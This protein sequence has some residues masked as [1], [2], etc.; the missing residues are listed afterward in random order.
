MSVVLLCAA[1]P[2]P[3]LLSPPKAFIWPADR[4][5][6]STIGHARR[7]SNP[8]DAYLDDPE[9]FTQPSFGPVVVYG[10]LRRHLQCGGLF[11][12][13]LNKPVHALSW[14]IPDPASLLPLLTARLRFMIDKGWQGKGLSMPKMDLALVADVCPDVAAVS[15]MVSASP[16]VA[17]SLRHDDTYELP[18]VHGDHAAA[19]VEGCL[20]L[21]T[22]TTL[23]LR[24][25]EGNG[26]STGAAGIATE[27]NAAA[28]T[29]E[30][31]SVLIRAVAFL[32][33]SAMPRGTSGVPGPG[34]FALVRA[35]GS[36]MSSV[37]SSALNA[38]TFRRLGGLQ[39]A[40][41]LLAFSRAIEVCRAACFRACMCLPGCVLSLAGCCRK[42]IVTH[43]GCCS[44]LPR[45]TRACATWTLRSPLQ[46]TSPWATTT[47]T[48]PRLETAA[49]KPAAATTMM[50]TR[51]WI[52][53]SRTQEV[54]WLTAARTRCHAHHLPAA[55]PK[56]C[57]PVVA[58]S[59][60][61]VRIP[62]A[63]QGPRNRVALVSDTLCTVS[64]LA[65]ATGAEDSSLAP[66][67]ETPTLT[68]A[69]QLARVL[70]RDTSDTDVLPLLLSRIRAVSLHTAEPQVCLVKQVLHYCIAA[71]DD[72]GNAV[73][74][75]WARGGASVVTG[76]RGSVTGHAGA[77][78][79]AGVGGATEVRTL[80][81]AL[82]AVKTVVELVMTPSTVL[83]LLLQHGLMW[84]L[85]H[86]VL[87]D[88]PVK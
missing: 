41:A 2:L 78:V 56:S 87:S 23:F 52:R 60:L 9:V 67:T 55:C 24:S 72:E 82:Q 31:Y 69:L 26:A 15:A 71:T 43:F 81:V 21:R 18:S 14:A 5:H 65:S 8:E 44:R 20:L 51:T 11:L 75:A 73:S 77:G 45:P 32:L 35:A 39:T 3:W 59:A 68:G 63:T 86:L 1:A 22:L 33:E 16:T 74:P 62:P 88:A 37:Q 85:M 79:G 64:R 17:P 50:T 25:Q 83:P 66:S 12:K 53:P 48:T 57:V 70:G 19:I 54:R 38:A 76:I 4:P 58:C 47:T 13:V 61:A 42:V 7:L 28:L 80:T 27:Y 84:Y 10:N 34:G 30:G 46:S 49:V 40:A 36:L 6:A 29:F